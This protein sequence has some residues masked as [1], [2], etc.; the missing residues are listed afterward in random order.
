[1]KI[2]TPEKESYL[3]SKIN[4]LNLLDIGTFG[5]GIFSIKALRSFSTFSPVLAEIRKTSCSLTFKR[6][7]NSFLV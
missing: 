2:T 4:A 6:V 5:Q 1:M 3:E 7:A